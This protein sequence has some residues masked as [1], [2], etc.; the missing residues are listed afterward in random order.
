MSKLKTLSKLFNN[1]I[2]RI[3]DY[4]RGYAWGDEQLTDFW[5]DIINLP[6]DKNHY[7][8]MISL[9]KLSKEDVEH[10]DENDKWILQDGVTEAFHVIDG[11]QRLTTSIILI[12]CILEFCKKKRINLENI[13]DIVQTYLF[14]QNKSG[15]LRTYKF[16]YEKNNP[17]YDYFKYKILE[18]DSVIKLEKSYYTANLNNAKQYFD[19]QL[20]EF[21]RDNPNKIEEILNKVTNFLQFNVYEIEEGFDVNVAFETMNNRGKKLSNLE[22]LKNRLIYLLTMYD[23]HVLSMPEKDSIRNKINEAWKEIYRQLGRDES[24]KLDDDE[25]LKNHWIMYF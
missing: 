2:F 10:W 15:I 20:E 24:N 16:G 3:P 13:E 4:Q 18:D 9:K 25:F 22:I 5:E 7:T 6:K 1:R 11:Q 8:G 23:D 14:S 17:S 19:K 21:I 12:N